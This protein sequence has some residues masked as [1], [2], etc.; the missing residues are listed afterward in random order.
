MV[1]KGGK[2]VAIRSLFVE[3]DKKSAGKYWVWLKI[4][5]GVRTIA[6]I[7]AFVLDDDDH[8]LEEVRAERKCH[9]MG[10]HTLKIGNNELPPL[11]LCLSEEAADK[12]VMIHL[13]VKSQRNP[14]VFH[15]K[16]HVINPKPV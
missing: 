16:S 14:A 6:R 15:Y 9:F 10:H 12:D 8:D 1:E 2:F 7:E 11:P 5:S 3:P 13:G 4:H